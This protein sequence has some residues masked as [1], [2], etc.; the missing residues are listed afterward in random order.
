MNTKQRFKVLLIAESAN[1]QWVSVPL[2]GWSLAKALSNVADIHLVTQIRNRLAILETGFV[3]NVDFTAIDSEVVMKPLWKLAS[4]MRGGE[5]KGW[6]T[7]SALSSLGY[8]YFEYLVWKK[9]KNSII[10]GDYDVV[11]RITPLSPAVPS[12]LAGQCSKYQ[13]PFIIGPL[14]GGVPWPR[15]FDQL[16]RKEKEWLS[17]VRNA[18]KLLPGYRSTLK[19]SAA[20]LIGSKDTYIKI[21]EKFHRKCVYLPENAIN[22]ECFSEESLPVSGGT[23]RACFVGRLVPYKGPD[24]LIEA[25]LPFLQSGRLRLDI[26]G[27]GPMMPVLQEMIKKEHLDQQVSLRG[28]VEHSRLQELM[29][30][31]QLFTFPSIR[32]F[33]GG[34]VLEAMALG[35]VP[36]V[37][38]YAGPGELVTEDCGFKIPIGSRDEIITNLRMTLGKVIDG[39][40][41]LQKYSTAAKKRVMSLFTWE[42]KAKQIAEVYDWVF[43]KNNNKPQFFGM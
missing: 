2:I 3:E 9:F 4:L 23:L 13:V 26:I 29:C 25:A 28:W 24:M 1:P 14:N 17:Y 27:D 35:L 5:G 39:T 43:E 20:L 12:L 22:S 10:K 41:H 6:T 7:V 18:Y 8:Y 40:L 38:D 42:K 34:V 16:R 33:G 31:S 36:V 15:G 19:S 21:P 37:V 11:H 30:R 32:E